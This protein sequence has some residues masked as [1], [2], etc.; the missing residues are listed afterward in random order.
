[1]ATAARADRTVEPADLNQRFAAV[2]AD[3]LLAVL[4]GGI[5]FQVLG[6]DWFL[7][8]LAVYVLAVDFPL[9]AW[10]GLSAGRLVTGTRVIR[11]SDGRPPGLRRAALRLLIVAT[12]GVVGSPL[13]VL[14][15]LVNQESSSDDL[16]MRWWWDRAS[17]TALL[18][19]QQWGRT[20][21]T[22]AELV[23]MRDHF[24]PPK[25]AR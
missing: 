8:G 25:P 18:S 20:N 3:G 24:H 2:F 12:T 13:F 23:R 5:A 10:R 1:M 22:E 6:F 15:W 11:L 21:L 4:F 7:V 16:N 19:S 17:D 14:L 9:T